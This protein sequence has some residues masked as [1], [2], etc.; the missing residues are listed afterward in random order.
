MKKVINTPVEEISVENCSED[1][2]Y[3][4]ERNC[5]FFVTRERF[6]G[7]N[8]VARCLN[9]LSRGN[10]HSGLSRSSL[11]ELLL[12]AIESGFQVF[13]FDSAEELMKWVLKNEN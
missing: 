3:G 8:F 12:N 1:L 5:R 2:Y 4:I 7:G 6:D 11:K 10:G 13:E 9:L